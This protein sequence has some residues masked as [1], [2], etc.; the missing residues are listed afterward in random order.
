MRKAAYIA[1]LGLYLVAGSCTH[2]KEKEAQAKKEEKQK[3][4]DHHLSLPAFIITSVNT[5]VEL[6]EESSKK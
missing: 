2:S 6:S 5:L 1:F 4:E 3:K